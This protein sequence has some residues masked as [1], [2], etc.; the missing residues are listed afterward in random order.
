MSVSYLSLLVYGV[1]AIAMAISMRHAKDIDAYI[2]GGRSA[3]WLGVGAAIFSLIGGGEIIAL[4]ALS[5]SYGFSAISLFIGYGIGFL[6]L[7]VH[8]PQIRALNPNNDF[9]SLPDFV[10]ERFGTLAGRVVFICSM[11]AFFSLLMVQV[12]AGGHL[13]SRLSDVSYTSA[14]IAIGVLVTGYLFIGGFRIVIATDILQGI[15]RFAL[16][17]ILVIGI[18][19]SIH[20]EARQVGIESLPLAYSVGLILTGFFSSIASADVWQRIYA[21]RSNHDA[22][23]GM[24]LGATAM[25]LFGLLLVLVGME[26]R[27]IDAA[28]I[29]DDAFV[30]VLSSGVSKSVM[31][32]AIGLVIISVLSTADTEIFLISSLVSREWMRFHSVHN[33]QERPDNFQSLSRGIVL[34]VGTLSIGA[35]LIFSDVLAI[36]SW[37]ISVLLVISPV[38]VSSLFASIDGKVVEQALLLNLGIF[39]VLGVSNQLSLENAYLIVIPGFAILGLLQLIHRGRDSS[40]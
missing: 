26:A 17:P 4:S 9:V 7:G 6:V 16:L 18:T 39:V 31:A 36:Y 25:I 29:A 15:A 8:A 34:G 37:L 12:S 23:W 38:I 27:I 5:F 28:S 24:S 19:G 33:Y 2:M 20:T 30:T 35:V 22:L 40:I 11:L 3:S 13:I 32:A 21:A 14:A 10:H 1:I